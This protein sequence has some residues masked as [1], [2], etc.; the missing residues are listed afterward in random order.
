MSQIAY[1]FLLEPTNEEKNI[2]DICHED[3][4]PK[5][6][7]LNKNLLTLG[8]G[9]PKFP[10]NLMVSKKKEGK[11]VISRQHATISKEVCRTFL[12]FLLVLVYIYK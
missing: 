6:L 7:L 5:C 3:V 9:S 8:R 10:V 2:L 1:L 11:E 4:V 12:L